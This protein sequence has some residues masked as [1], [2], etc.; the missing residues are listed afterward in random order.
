M[1][2]RAADLLVEVLRARGVRYVFGLPGTTEAALLDA[3][4][5]AAEVRYVLTLQEGVAVAMA[6]GYALATGHPAVA[7]LHTTVGTLA[8]LSL[9]YDAWRDRVPVVVLATHKH[10]RILGRG[11]F[12]TLPDTTALARPLVKWAHQT[13]TADQVAE[14]AE[15]AFQQAAAPPPGPAYLLVPED[16]LASLAPGPPP[17]PSPVPLPARPHRDA[18]VAARTRLLA[19][20]R[21]VLLAGSTLARPDAVDALADLVRRLTLPMLW[22]PWRALTAVPYPADD[23][24]FVGTYDAGHPA[25]QQADLVLALGASLFV[26]FA[27]PRAPEVPPHADLIHVHAEA[28]E[29]GRL[30]RPA[31]AV[32]ADPALFVRDLL[33]DPL[34]AVPHGGDHRATQRAAWI[35]RLRRLRDEQRAARLRTEWHGTPL[36]AHRVGAEMARV[37]PGDAVIVEEAVRSS[38][39]FLDGFP[40][41]PGQLFRTAGGALGWGVPAALGVQLA[42]PHHAVVAVVGDGSLHFTPQALWTG[43]RERLPVV[44]V[45][46]NNRK[47]LA[48]EAGV[49]R[50]RGAGETPAGTPGFD[51]SGVDHGTVARGYGALAAA[52]EHADQLGDV[53]AEALARARAE[54]R[55]CVVD[56]PVRDE[57]GA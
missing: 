26:E 25:V 4:R 51:L 1:S 6:H 11:G 27:P 50:L 56:V 2:R 54:A 24:Y 46:L 14:D 43:A 39:A 16:L 12:T 47:Y 13:L 36:S 8:G 40:L 52:V 45:V 32:R 10:S 5:E 9:L 34:V 30:Y 53:L 42:R 37:L 44:V 18:V 33:E 21:P 41:R 22:E 55:P 29:L 48:V 28:G 23:P 35:A 7:N 31:L 17:V 57:P 19:A 20:D 38:P 49:Q 15:R 3:L